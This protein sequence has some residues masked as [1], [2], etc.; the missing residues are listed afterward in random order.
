[1]Y[2]EKLMPILS[3]IERKDI[4]IAGGSVVGMVLS[5]VNSLITYT[6]NLTK[7]K[8]KYEN[9]RDEVI[10]SIEEAKNLRDKSIEAI[11]IDK[12]M[13]RKILDAYK[14]RKEEPQEY[15]NSIEKSAFFCIDV[16]NIALDTLK[17]A[18][19]ISKIGNRMLSSDFKICIL[20]SFASVEA[21]IENVKINA[22]EI[23]NEELRNRLTLE[24]QKILEEAKNIYRNV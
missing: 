3:D 5:I 9:V 17:L 19:K 12:K 11:D 1:M 15:E 4:D 20:Y 16:T 10:K 18:H 2:N 6:C 14:N 21:S 24:Y 13:V 22:L 7:D 23:Q 8:K